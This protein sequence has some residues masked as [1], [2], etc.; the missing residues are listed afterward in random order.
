MCSCRRCGQE[1]G[2]P[3]LRETRM[4]DQKRGETVRLR[5]KE[6][7]AEYRYMPEPDLPPLEID[8]AR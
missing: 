1:R 8:D 3:I 6:E 7:G 2:E 5:S 4:F